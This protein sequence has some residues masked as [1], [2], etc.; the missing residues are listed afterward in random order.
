MRVVTQPMIARLAPDEDDRRYLRKLA[1]TVVVAAGV[2]FLYR[3]ADLLLLVLGAALGALLLSTA[4]DWLRARSGLPRGVTLGIATLA[5][6]AIL[7]AMGWLFASELGDQSRKLIAELPGDWARA[8]AQLDAHPLGRMLVDSLQRAA[9]GDAVAQVTARLGRGTAQVAVN[10]IIILAGAVFFAAQPHIYRE[11]IVRLTPA[12][13]R[14]VAADTV[15]DLARSL[16]L[17]LLTQLIS[18]TIMGV[19][20]GLGLWLSGVK[21]PASLGLLGGLSEF[22][23]FVGPTLAMIPAIV[24]ALAGGGSIWGVIGTYAIVRA[25]QAYLITPLI[26]QRVVAVP[27]GLYLFLILAAGYAFGTFGLFFAGSLAVTV[28]TLFVRLYARETLGERVNLPGE[29]EMPPLRP[30]DRTPPVSSG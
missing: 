12:P 5:L 13:Q 27:A 23:P 6:F 25:V 18:M 22:I 20:I 3:I 9:Q 4:A 24:I 14:A 2:L 11:G 1:L 15:D 21:A 29:E 7:G 28:Y 10:F 17:W 8:S 19:L 30:A 16:R 26:S